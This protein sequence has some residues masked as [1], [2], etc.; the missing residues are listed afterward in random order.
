MRPSDAK[1]IFCCLE[2]TSIV[3]VEKYESGDG[4]MVIQAFT[5]AILSF[6][7]WD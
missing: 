1:T 3:N 7:Y 6:Q 5:K 4:F 2:H